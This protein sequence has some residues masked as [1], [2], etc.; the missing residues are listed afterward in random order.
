M[1]PRNVTVHT[2]D[3]EYV[4]RGEESEGAEGRQ[5]TRNAQYGGSSG[6]GREKPELE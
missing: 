6:A 3:S 4:T 2:D 1:G 5:V